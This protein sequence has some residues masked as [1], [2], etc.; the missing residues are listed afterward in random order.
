M[1]TVRSLYLY[2]FV[3]GGSGYLRQIG[4][5]PETMRA[6]SRARPKRCGTAPAIRSRT[7]MGVSGVSSP[8]GRSSARGSRIGTGRAS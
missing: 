1:T 8:I 7:G 4:E 6:V 5:H 2:D 3:P